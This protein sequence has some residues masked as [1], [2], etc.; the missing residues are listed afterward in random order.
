MPKISR[1]KLI[2]P[3]REMT[4]ED[5]AATLKPAFAPIVT[6]DR[7]RDSHHRIARLAAAGLRKHEIADKTGY[8]YTR[9]VQLL[10]APA[11]LELVARYRTKVDAAFEISQDEYYSSLLRTRVKANRQ[12]EDRLDEAEEKGLGLA[13]RDLVAIRADADDRVGFTKKQT[14]FNVNADFASALEKAIE[15]SGKV[16]EVIADDGKLRRRV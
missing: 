11:M 15:R 1:I 16:I 3:I 10:A 9:V 13:L 8:S 6:A 2:G 5:M 12:I 14:N 7:L 4:R